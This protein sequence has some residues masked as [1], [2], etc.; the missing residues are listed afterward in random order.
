[1]LVAAQRAAPGA[2][3][4][5]EPGLGSRLVEAVAEAAAG[6]LARG[7]PVALV[8]QP[9]PRRALWRLLRQRPAIPV[10]AFSEL[11]DSRAVEVTAVVGEELLEAPS[12]Q[13]EFS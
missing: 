4:P 3:Y 6:P 2:D 12:H 1:L 13:M 10:L 8:T 9:G 7:E 5:F 11:Q